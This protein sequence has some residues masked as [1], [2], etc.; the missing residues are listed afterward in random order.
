M[1]TKE[2]SEI[3]NSILDL[4]KSGAETDIVICEEIIAIISKTNFLMGLIIILLMS[5]AATWIYL[6]VCSMRP[7]VKP[8]SERER[9]E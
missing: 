4:I 1:N 9:N 5:Q 3:I 6:V 2:T 8:V 7:K